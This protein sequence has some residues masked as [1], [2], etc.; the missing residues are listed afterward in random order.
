M[1]ILAILVFCI[2]VKAF[3]A[4]TSSS[5]ERRYY[6]GE[7]SS[8]I[9]WDKIDPINFMDYNLWKIE[10]K[11][12]DKF[13]DW[14]SF[15]TETK[16]N[17]LVGRVIEC[18]GKCK[19]YKERGHFHASYRTGLYE[20]D[21][22]TTE[23][24]SYL[25]IFLLDGTI[26]RLSAETSIILKEFNVSKSEF[27][28]H[29]RVNA[30]QVAWLN[31]DDQE[32]MPRAQR[33]TDPVF[34]PLRFYKINL[35]YDDPALTEGELNKGTN[36]IHSSWRQYFRANKQ[37]KNNNAWLEKKRKPTYTFIVMPNG[38][39]YGKNLRAEFIVLTGDKSYVKKRS[40]YE[41]HEDIPKEEILD[42]FYRGFSNKS[43]MPLVLDQWYEIGARGR[44]LQYHDVNKLNLEV[45]NLFLKRIPSII[46]AREYFLQK[47]STH[48]YDSSIGEEEL[49][50]S[51]GYRTWGAIKKPKSDMNRRLAFLKE[52][53]RRSETTSLL[54]AQIY[55]RKLKRSGKDWKKVTYD[56]HFYGKA[57][58]ALATQNKIRN[59]YDPKSEVLNSTKNVFWKKINVRKKEF[60][61]NTR[62]SK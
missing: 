19:V 42:F 17:E 25:W 13:K 20:G 49:A 1:R 23:K 11:R 10:R 24:D 18:V 16:H 48:L 54:S 43:S 31:R 47:Y 5:T 2:G 58:G 7:S 3:A 52:Y 56:T 62:I 41:W 53:T 30:G 14:K 51:Y 22:I 34:L 35:E 37:I 39:V 28:I 6:L 21:E 50:R 55:R 45:N 8:L 38:T 26:V 60:E 4:E 36:D 59:E 29:A 12:R 9:E 33:E 61:I 40:Q 32:L 27:F 46:L 44:A 57:M 15:L